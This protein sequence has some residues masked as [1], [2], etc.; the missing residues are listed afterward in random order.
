MMDISSDFEGAIS[1]NDFLTLPQI[2]GMIDFKFD[3][4]DSTFFPS[5]LI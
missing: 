1:F 4:D 3:Y 5:F 2:L